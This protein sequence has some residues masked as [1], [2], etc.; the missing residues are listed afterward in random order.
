MP[1]NTDGGTRQP[2]ARSGVGRPK[3][4]DKAVLQKLEEAFLQG[5]TDRE[6]CLLADISPGTLY[7][8][9]H[10]HPDFLQ[11]KELLKQQ[12]R[13]LAKKNLYAA[14]CNGD[15]S[16]SQWYLE[17][18]AADEFS[19]RQQVEHTGGI[20]VDDVDISRLSDEE[21]RAHIARLAQHVMEG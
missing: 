18:R 13:I 12:P 7:N 1:T 4:V 10:A 19:A 5:M 8:Y 20:M 6:A 16:L 9:G 14:L 17:R 21:L 2:R 15:K 11:R 3:V